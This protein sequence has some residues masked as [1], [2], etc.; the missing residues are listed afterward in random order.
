M[1]GMLP[2]DPA[3]GHDPDPSILYDAATG[4]QTELPSPAGN[5]RGYYVA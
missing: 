2:N 4:T 1:S 5:Q 3:F